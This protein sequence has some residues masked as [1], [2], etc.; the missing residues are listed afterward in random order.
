M[1][2]ATFFFLGLA[3][4]LFAGLFCWSLARAAKTTKG[5]NMPAEEKAAWDQIKN[6]IIELHS[7]YESTETPKQKT[8]RSWA[9]TC[10]IC[11][12][13]CMIGIL[14]E[15]E[16]DKL[17]TPESI[18]S[19]WVRPTTVSCQRINRQPTTQHPA[20]TPTAKPTTTPATT[21]KP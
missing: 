10:I 7:R 4:C 14:L 20:A 6:A 9:G 12:G 17:I 11:A 8:L 19:S 2:T 3:V 1:F 13:L 21:P 16:Y 18:F 5:P 15:A